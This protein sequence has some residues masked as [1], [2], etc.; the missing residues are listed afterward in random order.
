[1]TKADFEEMATFAFE[2]ILTAEQIRLLCV[3]LKNTNPRFD[4]HRFI[5]WIK[6]LEETV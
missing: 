1:M 2:A 4:K 6:K 3:Y 5:A